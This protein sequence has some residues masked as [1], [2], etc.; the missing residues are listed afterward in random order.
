[1]RTEDLKK[2]AEKRNIE[3]EMGKLK[4]ANK[5]LK[6]HL[7]FKE[8]SYQEKVEYHSRLAEVSKKKLENDLEAIQK[9]YNQLLLRKQRVAGALHAIKK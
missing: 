9:R 3:T 7:E 5:E 2:V 4:D 6:L 1:M 8:K